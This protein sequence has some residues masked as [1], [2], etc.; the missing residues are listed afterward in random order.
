MPKNDLKHRSNY[1]LISMI[2]QL[3][4]D[5]IKQERTIRDKTEEISNLQYLVN[6]YTEFAHDMRKL[7]GKSENVMRDL[8]NFIMFLDRKVNLLCQV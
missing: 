8:S 6:V 3:R 1:Q 4:K 5:N 7:T 2:R